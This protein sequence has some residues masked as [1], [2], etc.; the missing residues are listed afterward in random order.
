MKKPRL[1]WPQDWEAFQVEN[2]SVPAGSKEV[3]MGL[4]GSLPGQEA[5]PNKSLDSSYATAFFPFFTI[6]FTVQSP[7]LK[8]E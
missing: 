4:A 8:P 5:G 1:A 7:S 2:G 6:H 3:G